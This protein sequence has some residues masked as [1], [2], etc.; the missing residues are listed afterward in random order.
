MLGHTRK[1]LTERR[2][3]QAHEEEE[4]VTADEFFKEAFGDRPKWS[5]ILAGSR[6]R[7]GY[8]QHQLG[9]LI[10]ASQYNISKMERGHRPIGKD[11][12]KRLAKVFD[13]DYRIFL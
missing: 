9:G 8:T 13:T 7:E 12:A 4:F 5:V 1:R 10:G 11:I 3:I 2:E 6:K